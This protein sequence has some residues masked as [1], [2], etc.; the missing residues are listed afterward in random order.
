MG[1]NEKKAASLMPRG[2]V[3]GVTIS[4]FERDANGIVALNFFQSD[5]V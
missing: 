2:A 5:G 4:M 3:G 1:F